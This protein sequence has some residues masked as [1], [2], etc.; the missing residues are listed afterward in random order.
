MHA[1]LL[2]IIERCVGFGG[3]G[4]NEPERRQQNERYTT[5]RAYDSRTS[6][7]GKRAAGRVEPC[8]LPPADGGGWQKRLNACRR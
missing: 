4:L 3:P 1:R 7:A 8:W 2:T 5:R 6:T